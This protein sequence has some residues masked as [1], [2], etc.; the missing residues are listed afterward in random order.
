MEHIPPCAAGGNGKAFTSRDQT[1]R[2]VS[3]PGRSDRAETGCFVPLQ[4]NQL[5]SE[6]LLL[7]LQGIPLSLFKEKKMCVVW[8]PCGSTDPYLSVKEA[9]LRRT[10]PAL[11]TA[12]QPPRC[13]QAAGQDGR[14]R[15]DIRAVSANQ[16]GFQ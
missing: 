1:R 13:S 10:F 9:S 5:K 4:D 6:L 16:K 11:V 7:L 3:S 2:R 8:S 14:A 15:Q 12:D